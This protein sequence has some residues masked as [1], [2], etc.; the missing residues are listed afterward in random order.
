MNKLKIALLIAAIG[1]DGSAVRHRTS[2]DEQLHRVP[3]IHHQDG[4]TGG[5]DHDD[6]GPSPVLQG[7]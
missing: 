5:L 7:L 6:Q 1:G 2:D 4:P 3:T